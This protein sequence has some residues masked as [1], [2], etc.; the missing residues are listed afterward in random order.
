MCNSFILITVLHCVILTL[1]LNKYICYP[2]VL[3]ASEMTYTVSGGALN[4][5]Q[6]NPLSYLI[7]RLVTMRYY[8]IRTRFEERTGC[9]KKLHH[10]FIAI[11][12]LLNQFSLM[13]GT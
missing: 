1:H 3:S 12:C 5:T 13:F 9:A 8:D 2:L 6:S 7:L 4:S 11:T 10:F